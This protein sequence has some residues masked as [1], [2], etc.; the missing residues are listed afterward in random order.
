[1]IGQPKPLDS[2]KNEYEGVVNVEVRGT[3]VS[4]GVAKGRARVAITLEDAKETR[5]CDQ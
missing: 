2:S 5:V 4:K 3:P 1:M